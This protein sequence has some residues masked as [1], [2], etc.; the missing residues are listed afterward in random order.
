MRP[1]PAEMDGGRCFNRSTVSLGYV[2]KWTF[3]MDWRRVLRT[4]INSV[5]W[6]HSD[7]S[8]LVI[9]SSAYSSTGC[10][11]LGQWYGF[12]VRLNCHMLDV[13]DRVPSNTFRP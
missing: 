3:L 1:F 6:Y 8:G 7:R 13:F 10:G 2:N 11:W 4:V 5:A 9:D 12:L